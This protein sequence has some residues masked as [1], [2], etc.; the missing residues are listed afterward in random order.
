MLLTI[1]APTDDR[2]LHY[3]AQELDTLLSAAFP[4]AA[5]WHFALEVDP[6]LE[7]FSWSVN[8]AEA[9]ATI[10]AHDSACVLH[11]VYDLLEQ[12]GYVFD[13]TGA[14]LRADASLARL[15]G[16]YSEVRPAV[17]WRGIR[18][19]LNFPMDISGYPMEEA[20][21][22][23][24]QLARMR[25][26]HITFHSYPDQWYAVT[27]ENITR[28]AGYYFYGQ[29]HDLPIH[30]LRSVIR[31]QHTFCIPEHEVEIDDI[32]ANSRNAQH[33]LGAMI[34]EA[35]RLGMRVQFSCELRE[36]D[37]ALSLATLN[38]ILTQYPQIDVLEIITQ[39][40]GEW[41]YAAPPE[42][43]RELAAQYFPGALDDVEIT[44]HLVAG[45]K[46]LDKLLREIGHAL[47][48]IDALRTAEAALPKLT[49]GVY[50]TVRSN[51]A[52]VLRL[53]QHYAPPD[54]SFAFLV[55]HGGRAVAR[56]LRDLAMPIQD[57]GRSLIYSW[58][59]FDGTIYLLQNALQ[60]ISDLLRLAGNVHGDKPISALAFNHWRSAENRTALRFAA[61]AMLTGS[62]VPE[63]FYGDYAR[64]FGIG[65]IED[66]MAGMVLIDDA[67]AQ[68][69]DDLPNVGF[70]YVGCWGDQGLGYYGVFQGDKAARVR[71][72]YEDAERHLER[73]LREPVSDAG[74]DYLTLLL[75]RLRCTIIYLEAIEVASGL[76]PICGNRPPEALSD[77]ERAA[78]LVICDRALELMEDYMARHAQMLPDRGTEG[79]LISFYYT[80]PYVLRRIRAEYAGVGT[81][82]GVKAHDAPP[83]PIWS[84]ALS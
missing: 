5:E 48:V 69:R 59:E 39:E 66:Y 46:D 2:T 27:H 16:C 73:C 67:E 15:L 28:H 51:H 58:I 50:C 36:Q 82:E 43:L 72:Q 61:Q 78:V 24:R 9:S 47:Q 62:T 34:D 65:S 70:C 56:N 75:N 37:I 30:P 17:Q 20:K 49:L 80:P 19:H 31:N 10:R 54:V 60:G 63:S 8:V 57:W 68:A 3:A 55:D 35:K 52:V 4:S 22:Y 26:N 1:N 23:L 18:Q 45:Q 21:D 64:A 83:S 38:N 42:A 76:Q 11:G 44:S 12:A 7:P 81:V 25:F 40:T 79:T 14:W 77:H 41:G 29:R 84:E 6:T 71:A 13:V 53:L 32:E 74:R 33:W